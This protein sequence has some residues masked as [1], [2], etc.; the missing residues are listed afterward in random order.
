M[1]MMSLPPPGPPHAEFTKQR[2]WLKALMPG[3]L[4]LSL[5]GLVQYAGYRHYRTGQQSYEPLPTRGDPP[6]EV[7][8]FTNER[9]VAPLVA[10]VTGDGVD[11]LLVPVLEGTN[12]SVALFDGARGFEQRMPANGW[13]AARVT[14]D[15]PPPLDLR[16]PI[17]TDDHI[18]LIYSS[19]W[20]LVFDR[21]LSYQ[22]PAELPRGVTTTWHPA[23]RPT[24]VIYGASSDDLAVS[25][26]LVTKEASLVTHPGCGAPDACPAKAPVLLGG[27]VPPPKL[28]NLKKAT[29]DAWA[30]AW[31]AAGDRFVATVRSRKGDSEVLAGG[32]TTTHDLDWF[33]PLE[34]NTG[35]GEHV[36]AR[37]G[38]TTMDAKQQVVFGIVEQP[39]KGDDEIF[40]RSIEKGT[41][42]WS[43][44][45]EPATT[46]LTVKNDRVYVAHHSDVTV[47]SAVDGG[48]IARVTSARVVRNGR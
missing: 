19:K 3:A 41:L 27:L 40:A 38:S 30:P 10:D 1:L 12:M 37:L 11:D 33:V 34:K 31:P 16:A 48:R 29:A 47:L 17:A 24:N 39:F 36:E 44:P 15:E 35:P 18:V 13:N 43:I 9:G 45:L 26:D 22:Y 23:D 46:G 8:T 21:D 4:I 25:L 32:S 20:A 2:P 14:W 6:S 7:V 5:F 28:Q 42:L